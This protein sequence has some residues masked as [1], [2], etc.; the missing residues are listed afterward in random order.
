[1]QSATEE[2]IKKM[3]ADKIFAEQILTC[4][5]NDEAIALAKEEGIDLTPENIVEVNEVLQ[6]AS[7]MEEG[8]LTEE[9]LEQVAGGTVEW[10]VTAGLTVLAASAV[11]GAAFY[12]TA[13]TISVV[14]T[15]VDIVKK[16]T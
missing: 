12:L 10:V 3:Q 9:E 2:L 5:E 6:F 4:K 8:E 15:V 14:A 13:A 7:R 16:H 11:S 1:M